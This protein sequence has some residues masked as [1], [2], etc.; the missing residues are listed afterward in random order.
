VISGFVINIFLSAV[1]VLVLYTGLDVEYF[2]GV[3]ILENGITACGYIFLFFKYNQSI[4]DWTFRFDTAKRILGQSWP[5]IL[6]TAFTVVYMRID[7]VMINHLLNRSSVGIYDAAVRLAEIWYFIPATIAGSLFPAV[8]NARISSIPLYEARLAKLY[9]VSFYVS[10]F[11]ILPITFLSGWIIQLLY[12][13]DYIAAGPVLKIY[14]WAGIFSML[15]VVVNQVLVHDKL[16]KITFMINL[17]AMCLNVALNI[18]FIPKWG[19]NGAAIA[20]LISY[21]TIPFSTVLF[22]STR[23]QSLLM[24]KALL[25]PKKYL[26]YEKE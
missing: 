13:I 25:L 11:I 10:L 8:V 4:F 1:K 26:S 20:T 16:T 15:G 9:S 5:L 23:K 17:I 6:S 3:F 21:A 24:I 18:L 22:R 14:V 19:I 12:G 7:Q 2:I